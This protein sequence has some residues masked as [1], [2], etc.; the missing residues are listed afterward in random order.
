MPYKIE[1]FRTLQTGTTAY[2]LDIFLLPRPLSHTVAAH[3][4][5]ASVLKELADV[6]AGDDTSLEC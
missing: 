5:L 4:V 2:K 6:V 3:L 1:D